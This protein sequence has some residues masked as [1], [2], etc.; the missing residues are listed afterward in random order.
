MRVGRSHPEIPPAP[1]GCGTLEVTFSLFTESL[2]AAGRGVALFANGDSETRARAAN[3][4]GSGTS[5][6]TLSFTTFAALQCATCPQGTWLQGR[7]VEPWPVDE[8]V[9]EWTASAGWYR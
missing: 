7:E 3:G 8:V 6:S 5:S 2:L 1:T 9:A 4:A